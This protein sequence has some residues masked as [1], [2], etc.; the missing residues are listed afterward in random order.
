MSKTRV[1]LPESIGKHNGYHNGETGENYCR[2]C[3]MGMRTGDRV[4]CFPL[5]LPPR[6]KRC[7]ECHGSLIEELDR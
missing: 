4:F 1:S 7:D 3:Y 6:S 2:T 5:L